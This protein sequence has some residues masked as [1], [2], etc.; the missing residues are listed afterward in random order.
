MALLYLDS[1]AAVKLLIPEMES[2]AMVALVA[3]FPLLASSVLMRLE[4]SR[5]LHRDPEERVFWR[6]RAQTLLE[7]IV[8]LDLTPP[9]LL[10]AE[11]LKPVSLRSLDAI[12]LATALTVQQLA[13]VVTYDRRMAEGARL[14]GLPAWSPGVEI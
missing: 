5:A 6:E 12:H 3:E 9:I 4:I 1:S 14:A 11:T 8:L 10:K 2:S 7:R 13:A